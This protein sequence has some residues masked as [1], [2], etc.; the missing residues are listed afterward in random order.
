MSSD[1]LN[2]YVNNVW[3]NS[4]SKYQNS[5]VGNYHLAKKNVHNQILFAPLENKISRSL[6]V[7]FFCFFFVFCCLFMSVVCVK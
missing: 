1:I 5:R 6:F 7:C 2:M 3:A 4:I